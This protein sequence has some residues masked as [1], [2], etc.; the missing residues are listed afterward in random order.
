MSQVLG[1]SEAWLLGYDVPIQKESS[2]IDFSPPNI[3]EEY[4]T[5]PVIGEIA[6]GYEHIAV[7]DW[8]GEKIEIPLSYL[9]GRKKEDFFVFCRFY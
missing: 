2:P 4:V 3:T 1:V 9:A 7:E 8:L 6:A 5:F